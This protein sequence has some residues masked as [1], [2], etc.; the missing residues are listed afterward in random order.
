MDN[1]VFSSLITLRI[2]GFL[3]FFNIL[4]HTEAVVRRCSVKKL[5]SEILQNSQENTFARDSFL[6]ELQA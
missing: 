3:Y 6:T 5:F 2:K 4:H 1:L